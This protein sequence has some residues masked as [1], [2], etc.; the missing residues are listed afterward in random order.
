LIFHFSVI[1]AFISNYLTL[2]NCQRNPE[3]TGNP[4]CRA[5]YR[6]LET[7]P[8]AGETAAGFE[9]VRK[10]PLFKNVI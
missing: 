3:A 4:L 7:V 6:Q 1:E 10:Q 5:V 9:K 2:Q 8:A